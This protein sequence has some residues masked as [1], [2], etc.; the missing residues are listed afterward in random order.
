MELHDLTPAPGS[1]RRA[2]RLGRGTGSGRGKTAGRGTKG[3][4]ARSGG[5][6]GA[7]FEGGQTPLVRRVPKRG[8]R[9][10]LRR[11]YAIV[12]VEQLN[13][14][15]DGTEVNP[16]LLLETGIVRALGDGVKVLGNGDLARRLTVRAHRFSRSAIAKI[17]AAGG[18]AEV[19]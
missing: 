15:D 8:F 18:R 11:E 2:R 5:A 7:P 1:R 14:F 12:N 16:E 17:E 13:Q 6:K 9:N 19:V 3:Q 10:P 4:K